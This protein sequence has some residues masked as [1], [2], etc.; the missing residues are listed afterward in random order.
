MQTEHSLD[1][2]SGNGMGHEGGRSW[3][4]P[5]AGAALGSGALVLLVRRRAKRRR[6]KEEAL[7]AA[8]EAANSARAKA[9]ALV[10][11]AAPIAA[12][13]AAK[14]APTARKVGS[15]LSDGVTKLTEDRRA[16]TWAL[17][18]LGTAWVLFRVSELRQLRRINRSLAV[19]R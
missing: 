16:R 9:A 17:A 18:G 13:A 2:Y 3:V 5:A 8:E 11:K 15:A 4:A 7:R 1:T 14:A 10:A 6:A 19:A 12:V